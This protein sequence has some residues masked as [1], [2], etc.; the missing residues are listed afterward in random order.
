LQLVISFFT[1]AGVVNLDAILKLYDEDRD[2]FVFLMKKCMLTIAFS[3]KKGSE[4]PL[5]KLSAML[6]RM[7][8]VRALDRY[9]VTPSLLTSYS[10]IC[11]GVCVSRTRVRST[12]WWRSHASSGL[13]E[14]Y[15]KDCE[16]LASRLKVQ[17]H[18]VRSITKR[19]ST[20]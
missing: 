2:K 12:H 11:L 4:S 16:N 8:E 13:S 14:S 20:G 19:S 10:R 17:L 7:F 5:K 1:N 15:K 6:L 3:S 18:S 9:G